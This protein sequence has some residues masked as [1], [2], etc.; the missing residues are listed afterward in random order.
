[1]QVPLKGPIIAAVEGDGD[2]A[3]Q[4]GPEN[5][6]AVLRLARRRGTEHR[7]RHVIQRLLCMQNYHPIFPK[8]ACPQDLLRLQLDPQP[9]Q[10]AH[11]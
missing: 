7:P 4:D 11:A 2:A 9:A 6:Y 10:T 1:M 5:P 8:L 3:L